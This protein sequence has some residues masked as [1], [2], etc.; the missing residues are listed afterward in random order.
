MNKLLS[1]KNLTK[2]YYSKKDEIEAIKDISFDLNEG[3]FVSIVGPSGC[4][5]STLLNILT[6]MDHETKGTIEFKNP[7]YQ[8]R[9]HASKW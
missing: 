5:K 4:G 2:V 9:I 7:E 6:G 8:A 3:E 1:I